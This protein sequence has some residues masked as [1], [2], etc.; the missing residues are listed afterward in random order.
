MS[1]V[2][3]RTTGGRKRKMFC[4][5]SSPKDLVK[6]SCSPDNQ[7]NTKGNLSLTTSFLPYESSI[8]RKGEESLCSGEGGWEGDGGGISC[9][10]CMNTFILSS[11]ESASARGYLLI[12]TSGALVVAGSSV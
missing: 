3:P 4:K 7:V 12:F 6:I 10:I 1:E 11:I 8:P 9:M 5:T 2:K